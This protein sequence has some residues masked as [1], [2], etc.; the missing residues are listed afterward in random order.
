MTSLPG[1]AL[2]RDDAIALLVSEVSPFA[3]STET[4]RGVE[5]DVFA[6]AQ[7]DLREFFAFS[8]THFADREFLVY[9]E[10]RLTFGVVHEQSYREYPKKKELEEPG[11]EAGFGDGKYK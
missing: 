8:N 4:I 3:L 5:F 1:G 2:T 10:E 9:G 11:Q 7:N 6:Y